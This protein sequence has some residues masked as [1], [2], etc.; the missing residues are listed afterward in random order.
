MVSSGSF[1]TIRSRMKS[2]WK[3]F[4][5]Q[6]AYIFLIIS[7]VNAVASSALIFLPHS[8]LPFVV[9]FGRVLSQRQLHARVD[10]PLAQFLPLLIGERRAFPAREAGHGEAAHAHDLAEDDTAVLRQIAADDV[11]DRGELVV[12]L[13]R[14]IE[15]AVLQAEK[16]LHAKL[17]ERSRW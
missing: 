4:F 6:R 14:L 9:M 8:S 5:C 17:G 3:I 10:Q 13:A 1:P 7:S 2:P 15:L 12:C 11:H 16:H